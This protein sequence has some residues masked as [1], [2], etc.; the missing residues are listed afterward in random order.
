MESW[1]T[2]REIDY[3]TFMLE[4]TVSFH[5]PAAI[6]IGFVE[7]SYTS[8][9]TEGQ[10]QVCAELKSGNLRVNVAVQFNTSDGNAIGRLVLMC[11][12]V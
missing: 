9:E 3:T 7:P 1:F 12:N 8:N 11:I 2:N 5:I 6:V 4:L 10:Q